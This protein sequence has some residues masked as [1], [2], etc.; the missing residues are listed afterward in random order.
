MVRLTEMMTTMSTTDDDNDD[1]GDDD[2]FMPQLILSFA[3]S[4]ACTR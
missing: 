2:T 1:D 4:A 3:P